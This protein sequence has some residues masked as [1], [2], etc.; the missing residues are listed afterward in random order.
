MLNI[1]QTAKY[2]GVL[3]DDQL[4][5][6]TQTK[7]L[8]LLQLVRYSSR[9]YKLKKNVPRKILIALELIIYG[10]IFGDNVAYMF[11]LHPVKEALSNIV[12]TNLTKIDAGKLPCSKPLT[13]KD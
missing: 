3:I 12:R 5:W 8:T 11:V 9:F 4:N 13:T 1:A 10:I 2:L 7:Q 6:L